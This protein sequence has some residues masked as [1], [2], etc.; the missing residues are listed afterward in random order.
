[1]DVVLWFS[2]DWLKFK[3]FQ[4]DGEDKITNYSAGLIVILEISEPLLGNLKVQL[5]FFFFNYYY[6]YFVVVLRRSLNPPVA[7][8]CSSGSS[9]KILNVFA[10][11]TEVD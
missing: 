8:L 2:S 11:N 10:V 9:A 1:M 4:Y 6:H 5:I 3:L 7:V